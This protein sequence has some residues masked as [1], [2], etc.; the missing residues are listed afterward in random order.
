MLSHV[1]LL[2]ARNIILTTPSICHWCPHQDGSTAPKGGQ[3]FAI[4]MMAIVDHPHA[5]MANLW[6]GAVNTLVGCEGRIILVTDP[7]L[8]CRSPYCH[9]I[10]S[11]SLSMPCRNSSLSCSNKD[12]LQ[13]SIKETQASLVFNAF[14]S[15]ATKLESGDL[16]LSF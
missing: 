8:C 14:S 2:K 1:S 16:S 15:V 13:L 10:E 6:C 3:F 4:I 9:N 11:A 7:A 12:I 5:S